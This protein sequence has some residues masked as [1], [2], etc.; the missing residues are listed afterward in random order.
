MGTRFCLL[1]TAIC[2]PVPGVLAQ[3][4]DIPANS[5]AIGIGYN[6]E[7]SHQF[8]DF[9]GIAER[10]GFTIG[11]FHFQGGVQNSRSKNFWSFKGRDLGLKTSGIAAAYNQYG[12]FKTF[13]NADQLSH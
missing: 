1:V 8:G 12:R 11:Q 10:G 4:V 7:D 3:A 6:S 2:L 5:L 9:S 13:L